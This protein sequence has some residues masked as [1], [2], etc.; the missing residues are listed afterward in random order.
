MFLVDMQYVSFSILTLIITAV[1]K[2]SKIFLSAPSVGADA[3]TFRGIAE[4]RTTLM[5][6]PK[7]VP[8]NPFQVKHLVAHPLHSL[9]CY[10]ACCEHP[11]YQY[12]ANGV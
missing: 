2:K 7:A 8:D 9:R 3:P 12:D 6:A 11:D 4:W 10:N 5:T 1:N